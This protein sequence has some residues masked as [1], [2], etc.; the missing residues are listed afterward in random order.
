MNK[1]FLISI[2][3]T[4]LA[5]SGCS[6]LTEANYAKLKVGMSYEETTQILGRAEQCSEVVGLKHCVWGATERNISADFVAD[7]ALVFSSNNIR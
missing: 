7:Q 4:V 1:I 3:I 5:L 6:K 2:A